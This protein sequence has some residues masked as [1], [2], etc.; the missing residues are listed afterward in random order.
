M[1]NFLNRNSLL[2]FSHSKIST[3]VGLK[4]QRDDNFFTLVFHQTT[5]SRVRY[6]MPRKDF[7]FFHIFKELFVFAIAKKPA[8]AKY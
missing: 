7:K 2:W 6:G 5:S 4:V 3:F 8:G 1:A